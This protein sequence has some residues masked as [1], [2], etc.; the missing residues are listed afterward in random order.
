MVV[1]GR[2]HTGR[3]IHCGDHHRRRSWAAGQKH[4]RNVSYDNIR[5]PSIDY[6]PAR[7]DAP[8]INNNSSSDDHDSPP[9]HDHHCPTDDDSSYNHVAAYDCPAASHFGPWRRRPELHATD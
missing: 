5:S 8:P 9:G 1:L 7:D 6:T 2:I 3:L 4:R